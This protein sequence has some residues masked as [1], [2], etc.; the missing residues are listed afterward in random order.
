MDYTISKRVS[1]GFDEVI[2]KLKD[3]LQIEGFGVITEIDL[4]EKFREK[5][6]ADFRRYTILGAC[7]P[8]LAFEVIGREPNI[9]VMP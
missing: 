8:K 4:K 1:Q 9:G 2:S 3:Q 7:N 6:Q 5:L